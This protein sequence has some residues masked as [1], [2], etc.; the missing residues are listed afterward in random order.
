MFNIHKEESLLVIF[1]M[2]YSKLK[3]FKKSM[4]FFDML[5][6]NKQKLVNICNIFY[7]PKV[8]YNLLSNNTIKKA[9]YLILAK[10]MK[11]SVLNDE[12]NIVFQPLKLELAI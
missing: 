7:S 11:I 5:I 4:I 10:K 3:V 12:N 1:I 8:E 9:N 6:N 2:D